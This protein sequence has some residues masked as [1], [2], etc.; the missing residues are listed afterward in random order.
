M[1][2]HDTPEK[3][4]DLERLIFFSDGV[5]AIA[6]TI[7]VIE[8]HP[9]EGW[10]GSWTTLLH[11]LLGKVVCYVI[12][13]S[14]LAAFWTAHRFIFRHVQKFS[15]PASLLNLLF[16]LSLSLIPFANA[17]LI[18]HVAQPVATQ[19]YVGLVMIAST[20][21]ALLW[22]Y[23]AL[24]ARHID[25]RIGWA[26]RWVVLARL[27]IMPPLLCFSS[28]WVGQHFGVLPSVLFT[29][30]VAAVAGRFGV[31]PMPAEPTV[32]EV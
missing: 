1:K 18:E 17:L 6:V 4:Y 27:L 5:F 9:P 24:I 22:A 15:E 19:A 30:V 20:V 14:A 29:A 2:T 26:F 3:T 16:L 8:L 21:M 12:S 10:D 23:L 13:F 7:L 11:G 25:P 28:I 31:K 32:K